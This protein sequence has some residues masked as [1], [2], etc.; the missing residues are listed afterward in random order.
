MVTKALQSGQGYLPVCRHYSRG[1]ES[2]GCHTARN[3][4]D[5][6]N[7]DADSTD[8]LLWVRH[9]FFFPEKFIFGP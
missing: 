7:D 1:A 4:T 6:D 2:A 9:H 5:D 3:I 8:H